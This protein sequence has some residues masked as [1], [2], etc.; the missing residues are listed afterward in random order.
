[1][2]NS[3][4][5]GNGKWATNTNTVLAYNDENEN[6]K[7][8]PF[9]FSRASNATVVN[10]NGLIET[11]AS[12][13]PRIDFQGNTKGALKLEPSRTNLVTYSED[14]FTGTWSGTRVSEG[15]T[16]V[17][18][19]GNN[20]AHKLVPN[21][22]NNTHYRNFTISSASAGSYSGSAFFKKGE[23]NVGVVRI[24]VD[25]SSNRYAVAINLENGNFISSDSVGTPTGTSYKIEDYGNGWY[26][27]SVSITHTSGNVI[28]NVSVAPSSFSWSSALPL[29]AGDATSGAYS[30]GA[31]LEAGSYAT[32]LINTSGSAVTRVADVCSQT[33]P[34]GVIGQIEGTFYTEF[35]RLGLGSAN[36]ALVSVTDGTSNNRL[37]I[38]STSAFGLRFIFQL[39]GN[40]IQYDIYTTSSF[41][42]SYTQLL[43]VAVAYK[44]GDIAVYINGELFNASSNTLTF[45]ASLN[46]YQLEN[47]ST[48]NIVRDAKLYNTRLSNA[49]LQALTTI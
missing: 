22:D 18:P 11:V 27:L 23:H 38:I 32:S 44:S 29:Y 20:S 6:F 15:S 19:D 17:S 21:T 16:I 28:L 3:L 25:T 34:D 46:T 47:G 4:K 13:E 5:F 35:S 31:Q 33:V 1:M 2:A 10:Q 9:T 30:W 45:S 12:G 36:Y 8:L 39:N 26:K 48:S 43:K 42:D 40:A 24:D 41:V 37:R 49:E 7:P 14:F